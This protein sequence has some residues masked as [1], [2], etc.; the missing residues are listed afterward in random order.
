MRMVVLDTNFLLHC[1]D[2]KIDFM[3][4]LERVLDER[5]EIFVMDRTLK[6]LAG[7]KQEQLARALIEKL[8]IKLIKAAEGMSV[9]NALLCLPSDVII[10]TQD[11]A[12]KE[13]LKKRG[14]SVIAIRQRQYLTMV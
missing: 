3:R 5:F 9:D 11:K 13:K 12:L 7:K 4:E 1:I 2:F 10:G 6:E 14:L 8:G